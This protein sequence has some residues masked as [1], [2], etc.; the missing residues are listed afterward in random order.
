MDK[1]LGISTGMQNMQQLGT[2]AQLW[3]LSWF[4]TLLLWVTSFIFGLRIAPLYLFV[5]FSPPVPESCTWV[6][7]Q[8][9]TKICLACLTLF[10]LHIDES[11]PTPE[12]QSSLLSRLCVWTW[13]RNCVDVCASV[14]RQKSGGDR[15]GWM[16]PPGEKMSGITAFSTQL[17]PKTDGASKHCS[18]AK[19]MATACTRQQEACQANQRGEHIAI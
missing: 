3:Y 18:G 15:A 9:S 2:A 17:T 6:F 7:W 19:T 1:I 14:W 12:Q 11:C 10:C 5:F 16:P 13:G 8:E 4:N